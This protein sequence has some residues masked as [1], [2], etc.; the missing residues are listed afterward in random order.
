MKRHYRHGLYATFRHA[1]EKV[2]PA[3]ISNP[4]PSRFPPPIDHGP[5]DRAT[6][7]L[8]ANN[9]E[10]LS[11]LSSPLAQKI[12]SQRSARFHH[13]NSVSVRFLSLSE[14][15]AINYRVSARE[16][17]RRSIAKV[18]DA[19]WSATVLLLEF[20][21]LL[22]IGITST[23]PSPIQQ[24]ALVICGIL[25]LAHWIM[26]IKN[27]EWYMILAEIGVFALVALLLLAIFAAAFSGI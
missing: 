27:G 2:F 6:V 25:L 3:P 19:H 23:A 15:P 22:L 16:G 1:K 5:D 17:R 4:E 9:I 11:L 26:L 14:L 7:S 21:G 10:S 20:L 24:I 12:A 13:S 8:K 18:G